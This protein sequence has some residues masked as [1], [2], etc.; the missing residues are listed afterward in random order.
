MTPPEE[1]DDLF[2]D[3]LSPHATPP[4]EALWARLQ[5]RPT[6]G[7][8]A[9]DEAPRLDALFRNGLDAHPTPPPRA[10][11][12]RLEDEHLRPRR[13]GAAWWPRALAA[14]VALLLLAGGGLW[15]THPSGREAR[16]SSAEIPRPSLRPEPRTRAV[17][18]A[19]AATTERPSVLALGPHP[20][21]P[22]AMPAFEPAVRAPLTRLGAHP[23]ATHRAAPR[24]T[25]FLDTAPH[26]ERGRAPTNSAAQGPRPAR[27]VVATTPPPAPELAAVPA[28]S[29]VE[30]VR[31]ADL[32][33]AEG[34]ILV[35][36]RGGVA[37]GAAGP[38]PAAAAAGE[39]PGLGNRL[40]RQA[41]HL[42][43]GE[44]LSLAEATGLPETVT[45]RATVAG[46]SIS[47]SI[48]L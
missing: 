10:V 3:R 34:V 15:W 48:R 30:A 23:L 4:D 39:R 5:A 25:L 42:V 2:R 41:G 16:I 33:G 21:A 28:P 45:L 8:P 36:V 19:P 32:A 12:E 35:E 13:R 31:P 17:P 18:Q 43:R 44:R 9:P 7:A 24:R 14:A 6:G 1:L 27:P 22:P 40:L 37:A 38:A 26:P 29:S 46:R 47:T 20:P 11:W